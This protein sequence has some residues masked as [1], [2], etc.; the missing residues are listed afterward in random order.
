M[1]TSVLNYDQR[2]IVEEIPSVKDFSNVYFYTIKSKLDTEYIEI[3][4]KIIGLNDS[5]LSKWLNITPRTFRNYKNNHNL[6]LKEN[7][8]EHIILIL[9]LYKHGFEVFDSIENFENWLSKK[10]VMLD[11]TAPVDFLE[12]I[13]GIK[14]IDNRLTAMEFGENV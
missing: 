14:F 12:T 2:R 1:T 3:L 7:T 6:V 10:N 5:V 8:K 9:S 13:S 11:N 4:D